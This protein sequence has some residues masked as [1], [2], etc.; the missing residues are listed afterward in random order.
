MRIQIQNTAPVRYQPITPRGLLS[1]LV[2]R[3]PY[4]IGYKAVF[5]IRGSK[6]LDVQDPD[7]LVRGTD[8]DP[9]PPIIKQK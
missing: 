7:P 4:G 2:N 8:P 9:D 6:F 1:E 5:R 3:V